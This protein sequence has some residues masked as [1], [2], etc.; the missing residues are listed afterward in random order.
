MAINI[1]TANG[2]TAYDTY[3]YICDFETDVKDLPVKGKAGSRAYIVE[4]GKVYILNTQKKWVAIN[5]S[6]SGGVTSYDDLTNK[7]SINNVTLS[8]NKT[9]DDLSLQGK[10][11]AGNNITIDEDNVISA[12]GG[13]VTS[14]EDL[15]D[16]PSIND[17]SLE[18]NKSASDLGL[19]QKLAE[20]DNREIIGVASSGDM[21][22]SGY[23]F[24]DSKSAIV[25]QSQSKVLIPN[26]QAI[27][28]AIGSS[29]IVSGS[30]DENGH[31]EFTD[32]DGNKFTT[33]GESVIGPQGDDYV[34]TAQDKSDIADIVLSELPNADTMSF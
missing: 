2:K 32:F 7:P 22:R 15:T 34:L 10:L 16:K 26:A 31:I 28:Q 4:T 25:D 30:I 33:T 29:K 17:I 12:E 13:G 5:R 1:M 20:G 24:T 11:T 6:S 14:Y 27:A 19:Q 18:G 8:G 3:E 21:R 23:Y 9:S